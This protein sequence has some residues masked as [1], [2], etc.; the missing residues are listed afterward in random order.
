MVCDAVGLI[1][2]YVS[3]GCVVIA[4]FSIGLWWMLRFGL[5]LVIFGFGGCFCFVLL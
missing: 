1:D 5:R 4:G 2:C 3:L